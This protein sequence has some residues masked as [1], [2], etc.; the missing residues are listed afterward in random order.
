MPIKP[1]P[2]DPVFSEEIDRFLNQI[3]FEEI[4]H[5]VMLP[6]AADF[7]KELC[8]TLTNLKL[9]DES[10]YSDEDI[11]NNVPMD[12]SD[13]DTGSVIFLGES[14]MIDEKGEKGSSE[15]EDEDV[16]VIMVDPD[17]TIPLP[18]F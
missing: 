3:L 4:S 1:E 16:L 17:D 14:G 10:Y 11:F 13:D 5:T 9:I 8:S 7:G 6:S 2:L 12:S 15:S 18:D